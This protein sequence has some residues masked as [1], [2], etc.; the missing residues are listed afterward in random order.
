MNHPSGT[1]LHDQVY[2]FMKPDPHVEDCASCRTAVERIRLERE[3]LDQILFVRLDPL[4]GRPIGMRILRPQR[5]GFPLA[6]MLAASAGLIFTLVLIFATVRPKAQPPLSTRD[7]P[8]AVI[9]LLADGIRKAT[10]LTVHFNRTNLTGDRSEVDSGSFILKEDNQIAFS[11]RLALKLSGGQETEY[12]L[13]SNGTKVLSLVRNAG[14]VVKETTGVAVEGL[15]ERLSDRFAF[16]GILDVASL[17]R[18]GSLPEDSKS[19]L[20]KQAAPEEFQWG[21]SEGDAKSI[22]FRLGSARQATRIRLWY[23]PK[24]LRLLKRQVEDPVRGSYLETYREY[25]INEAVADKCFDFPPGRDD[26]DDTAISFESY[27]DWKA[28][29]RIEEVWIRQHSLIA[30][31]TEP[32]L[33]D[34]KSYRKVRAFLP[35]E[36]QGPENIAKLTAGIIPNRV[37]L[38]EAG[39]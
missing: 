29:G 35:P 39:K 9:N 33:R 5:S 32:V 37:H 27:L 17:L 38:S 24:S 28:K 25:G 15:R 14:T 18:P 26:T 11:R 23:E 36:M 16:G 12:V 2:G 20:W 4:P 13:I 30:D 7:D 3:S 31:L 19:P 34:G 10:T 8:E 22:A 1:R 6:G 21:E